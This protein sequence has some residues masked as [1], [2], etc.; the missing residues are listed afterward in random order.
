[1]PLKDFVWWQ[2]KEVY[3]KL[4]NN[5][6]SER[7]S[8]KEQGPVGL[9]DTSLSMF[10]PVLVF[11]EWPSASVTF[12]EFQKTGS[13]V[14]NQGRD[15]TQRWGQSMRYRCSPKRGSSGATLGQD[16]GSSSGMMHSN[17]FESFCRT[18]TPYK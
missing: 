16:P 12:P 7:S 10:P 8:E 13:M 15:G 5:S 14:A 6:V 4:R 1:M 11:W 9:L 18:E 2:Q 17:V 3:L